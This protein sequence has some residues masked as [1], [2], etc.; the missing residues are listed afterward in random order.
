MEYHIKTVQQVWKL[1]GVTYLPHYEKPNVFVGPGWT[2]R[3]EDENG[4]V[5]Y[6]P[7]EYSLLDLISKQAVAA[8]MFLWKR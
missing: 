4:H 8:E 6:Y 7:P 2:V 1:N 3:V 5:K